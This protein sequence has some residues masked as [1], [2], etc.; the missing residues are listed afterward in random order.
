MVLGQR[1][2]EELVEYR[3]AA[4]TCNEVLAAVPEYGGA[5]L[6]HVSHISR[7][8]LAKTRRILDSVTSRRFRA[9]VQE[10]RGGN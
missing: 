1:S 10:S 7:V 3:E 5:L 8:S 9:S 6:V 4:E 2:I